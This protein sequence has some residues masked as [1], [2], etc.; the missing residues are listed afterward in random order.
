[1][2]QKFR[3][4][5]TSADPLSLFVAVAHAMRRSPTGS[6][7]NIARTAGLTRRETYRTLRTMQRYGLARPVGRGTWELVANDV[8]ANPQ[9]AA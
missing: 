3:R 6:P 4:R 5:H 8:S 1:M 9:E 7:R 2:Q